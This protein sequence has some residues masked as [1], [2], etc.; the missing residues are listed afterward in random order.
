MTNLQFHI[1]DNCPSGHVY[2]IHDFN[3]P[4]IKI[5][6]KHKFDAPF[7][8]KTGPKAEVE[9]T[10]TVGPKQVKGQL[11]ELRH[12]PKENADCTGRTKYTVHK[13]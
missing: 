1:K 3:F 6:S 4:P 7:A 8:A 10:G 2:A 5:N 12:I 11:F 13:Q 9:I